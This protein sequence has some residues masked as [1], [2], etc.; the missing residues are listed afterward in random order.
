MQFQSTTYLPKCFNL[1]SKH[2]TVYK[3]MDRFGILNLNSCKPGTVPSSLARLACLA[4][5]PHIN[6]K[7]AFHPTRTLNQISTPFMMDPQGRTSNM[8]MVSGHIRKA[9]LSPPPQAQKQKLRKKLGPPFLPGC[10][11]RASTTSDTVVPH[12][13]YSHKIKY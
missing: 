6:S 7:P 1:L 8:V 9:A 11:V 5:N 10:A 2:S 12:S 13:E 3:D 4:S